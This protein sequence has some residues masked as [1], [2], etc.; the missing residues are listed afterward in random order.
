MINFDVIK[1]LKASF[2]KNFE[3]LIFKSI[4]HIVFKDEM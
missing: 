1:I 2:D 3:I 4:I